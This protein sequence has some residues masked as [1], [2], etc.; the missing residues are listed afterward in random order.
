MQVVLAGRPNAG[1]S[2][3]FNQLLEEDRAI[4]SDIAGTTRDALEDQLVINGIRFRLIDTAGLREATDTIEKQGIERTY[5]HLAAG[6]LA[7]FVFDITTASKDELTADL[8]ALAAHSARIVAVGNKL[9]LKG[10]DKAL[11]EAEWHAAARE[12]GA[13]ELICISG[14][15]AGHREILRELLYQ[16]VVDEGIS[17]DQSLV[18]TVRHYNALADSAKALEKVIDAITAGVSG[19]LLAFEIRHALTALGEITG[20]ITTDDLLDHIFSKFCIGK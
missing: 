18:T 7:L 17:P 11:E 3:L 6:A 2:T 13:E 12:G 14:K 16:K 1:K 9:D 5:R 8:K 4:V 15:N 20:E 19:E 10:A